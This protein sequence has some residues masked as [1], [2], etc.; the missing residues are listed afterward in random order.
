MNYLFLTGMGRSGTT[1]LAMLLNN[2]SD[3]ILHSQP[4]PYLFIEHKKSFLNRIGRQEYYVLNNSII[5][6]YYS[7]EEFKDFVHNHIL[8]THDLEL[9]FNNM[10]DYSGQMT[11]FK[12]HLNTTNSIS[13][14]LIDTYTQLIKELSKSKTYSYCGSKEILCE[15]YLSS[16]LDNKFKCII[17]VRDPRDVLA[18]VNYPKGK[19]YLGEKKPALFILRS[20]RKSIEFAEYLK[21]YPNLLII[22]YEDLV[23][24]TCNE[25]NKIS[26]FLDISKFNMKILQNGIMDQSGKPW[27]P[28]SPHIKTHFLSS[29]SIGKYHVLLN[30]EEIRYVEC[31]C[32]KELKIMGYSFNFALTDCL[33]TISNYRDYGLSKDSRLP[34]NYS[35]SSTNVYY[36]INRF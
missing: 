4:F 35:S 7:H 18:S 31:I 15:E 16:M 33:K 17:I 5:D 12:Y 1:L 13:G 30:E 14:R 8:S 32:H 27:T 23:N 2:H 28:N 34:I 26:N 22:R 10:R 11:R 3:V 25:L 19:K 36:E 24:N 9:I 6:N 20:W 29:E 21:K